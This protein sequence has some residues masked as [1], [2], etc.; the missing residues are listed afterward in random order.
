MLLPN[1][2]TCIRFFHNAIEPECFDDCSRQDMR[3]WLDSSTG[4]LSHYMMSLLHADCDEF[5]KN[6]HLKIEGLGHST[7]KKPYNFLFRI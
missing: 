6:F 4:H 5:S 7:P 3:Y 2:L 1:W